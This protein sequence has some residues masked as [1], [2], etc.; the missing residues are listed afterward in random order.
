M[1]KKT[2]RFTYS[3]L[4]E[5]NPNTSFVFF[6]I[7]LNIIPAST[8]KPSKWYF[9]QTRSVSAIRPTQRILHNLITPSHVLQPPLSSALLIPSILFKIL[10]S[11]TQSLY[12]NFL[13]SETNFNSHTKQKAEL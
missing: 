1:F 8:R 11:K 7:H 5:S 2:C 6:Q 4:Q 12:I 13:M 10:F 3:G 9:L